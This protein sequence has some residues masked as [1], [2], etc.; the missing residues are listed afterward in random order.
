M[1]L[2]DVFFADM[3]LLSESPES[4][5]Y[6]SQ[7]GCVQDSSLNDKQLFDSVMVRRFLFHAYC[8]VLN[9]RGRHLSLYRVCDSALQ[10][11]QEL[12]AKVSRDLKDDYDM[13]ASEA[14]L[15][16]ASYMC[17]LAAS[18]NHMRYNHC[19]ISIGVARARV[20]TCCL[21][22]PVLRL[23][24]RPWKWW[25]SA[26]R[27]SETCSSC[28]LLSSRWA[29]S[30]LW[31]P[32]ERRSLPKGVGEEMQKG[33]KTHPQYVSHCWHSKPCK[34]LVLLRQTYLGHYF[35]SYFSF[36]VQWLSELIF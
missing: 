35:N 2:F 36:P 15:K 17:F 16:F 8:L 19:H 24:R 6:L 13:F 30:N 18:R 29:T 33:N 12:R 34:Y 9:P 26:R 25:N 7:S 5:H 21:T 27:R 31:L 10:R 11:A 4:Y 28:C 22:W 32:G 20:A 14:P 3:Y 1:G 23:C